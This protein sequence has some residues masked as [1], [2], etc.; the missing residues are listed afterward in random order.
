MD[1]Q[2]LLSSQG[3]VST[4]QYAV[5]L[6]KDGKR[7]K[8]FNYN[9]LWV[10]PMYLWVPPLYLC[11][12]PVYLWVPPVYLWVPPLYPLSVA[13]YLSSGHTFCCH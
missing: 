9:N 10:H 13:M 6:L 5:G 3:T 1:K 11:L 2:V 8:K 4:S 12:H 7:T